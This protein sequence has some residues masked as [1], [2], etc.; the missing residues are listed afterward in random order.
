VND[1]FTIPDDALEEATAYG[2]MTGL[3]PKKLEGTVIDDRDATIEGKWTKGEGLKPFVGF[4]YRY[5]GSDTG[6]SMRFNH[7][8]AGAGEVDVR[9]AYQSH[10]NRGTQVPITVTGPNGVLF[11]TKVDMTKPSPQ[12]NGFL[13]I[14]IVKAVEGTLSVTIGTA[15][16]GGTVHADA[17]QL[18]PATP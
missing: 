14:G 7:S 17:V 9:I 16:A 13:S 12:P 10:E 5:T 4:S 2:P 3:D 1:S 15:E 18:I 8:M 6:A 11:E